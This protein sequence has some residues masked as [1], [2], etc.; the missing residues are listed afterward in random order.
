MEQVIIGVDPHKLSATI[1]VVDDH[2]RMLGQGRFTTDRAGYSAMRAYA[3]TWPQRVWAVE[4][5]NG[6]GRPL[7]QRLLESGEQVVDVP[8]KLAA[9]V[10]LFDSGHN[11]KTDAH[12]A[13]A[14]AMVAVRTKGLR[15]L[16]VYA[17]LEALR[18]L[19]ERREA[20]TRRRVQTVGSKLCSQNC[21]RDRRRRTSPPARPSACSPRSVRATSPGRHGDG[22]LPRS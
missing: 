15:V 6:V 5:A 7:A 21:F 11:R 19:V 8:A 20:L 17:E 16:Q 14:V 12:D 22:S 13:H 10:R 1:E 18:L 3:K 9:R 2:E 4:G